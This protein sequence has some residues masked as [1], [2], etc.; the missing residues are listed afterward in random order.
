MNNTNSTKTLGNMNSYD[1][2][3]V[4]VLWIVVLSWRCFTNDENYFL[5]CFIRFGYCSISSLSITNVV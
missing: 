2:K 5:L 4:L 3:F 1:S